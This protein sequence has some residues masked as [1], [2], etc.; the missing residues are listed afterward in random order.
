M[1][2]EALPVN[3]SFSHWWVVMPTGICSRG[4]SCFGR[5]RFPDVSFFILNVLINF[6]MANLGIP[7]SA[8]L[9]YGAAHLTQLETVSFLP[10]AY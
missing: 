10:L 8:A 1:V 7:P 5:P 2:A 4:A 6:K 3:R 9:R